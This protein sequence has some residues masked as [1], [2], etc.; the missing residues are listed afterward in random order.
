M[1]PAFNVLIV[2]AIAVLIGNR[3]LTRMETHGAGWVSCEKGSELV[4]L[5]A[6]ARGFSAS[7]AR[8]QG[9]NFRSSCLVSGQAQS[10][11]VAA[12]D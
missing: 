8:S 10:G 5:E 2:I 4:R 6:L 12:H 9:E 1:R 11:K 7:G 3:V